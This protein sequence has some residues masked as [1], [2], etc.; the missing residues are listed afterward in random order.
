MF[1]YKINCISISTLYTSHKSMKSKM[2]SDSP[3]VLMVTLQNLHSG[4]I[5]KWVLYFHLTMP[6]N[7]YASSIKKIREIQGNTRPMVDPHHTVINKFCWIQKLRWHHLGPKKL[8]RPIGNLQWTNGMSIY[9]SV[10][11]CTS[12]L[13]GTLKHSVGFIATSFFLFSE[14]SHGTSVLRIWCYHTFPRLIGF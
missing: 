4:K 6:Y 9:L 5:R 10:L 3:G 14:R 11:T 13:H 8:G 1:P 12:F 7:R 2:F